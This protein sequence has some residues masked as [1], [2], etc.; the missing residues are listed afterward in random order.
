MKQIHFFIAV[1]F[2]AAVSCTT[3]KNLEQV[4][5]AH[6]YQQE[7]VVLKPLFRIYNVDETTTRV[8]FSGSSDQLLYVKEQSATDY[9]ARLE[10]KFA[11]YS[12][13]KRTILIDSGSVLITDIQKSPQ[14]SIVKG[15]FDM[16]IKYPTSTEMYVLE[17]QLTDKNRNLTYL[18][19][20][21]VDRSDVQTRQNFLL[22]TT[23]GRV[24]FQ[25]HY[26]LN[27]PFLLKNNQD[28][29]T[30]FVRYYNRE[31]PLAATPYAKNEESSFSYKAD[32]TF[33]VSATD[34]LVLSK[35][36]FYHFQL[37]ETTKNGFTLFCF[38][39][40]FPLITRKQNLG[41]PLRYLTTKEEF[42]GINDTNDQKM[43]LAVDKF[44]LRMA[45]NVDR[46]KALVSAYYGRVEDANL[47][48]T[49]YLEGWKTDRGIIYVVLGP[50]TEVRR[51]E[52]QEMWI[53]GDP[54]SSLSYVFTFT[55]LKN[56][57]SSN[58]FALNRSTNYRYG[59]AQAIESWRNGQIYSS[60]EI[61]RAQD[62]RDRQTRISGPTN[63]WY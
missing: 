10:I 5:L 42:A 6:L 17:V 26:P 7:G 29:K 60:K 38:Y 8:Y 62:E 37:N 30:Y 35:T 43:K 22:T 63:F 27:V 53:Y 52:Y 12:D 33:T 39:N 4:N 1:F 48:F 40:E 44:W 21:S 56:P 34:T 14:T 61:K 58:D 46:G 45:G 9:M 3:T 23:L 28:A 51:N 32:S 16:H 31:F 59:W 47:Y 2:L 50:P 49:S 13:Y 41:P 54:N 55:K 18:D 20:L 15:E 36:G 24:V 25:N 57:F 11:L 19:I